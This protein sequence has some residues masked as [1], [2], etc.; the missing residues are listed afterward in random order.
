M[1]K[2]KGKYYGKMIT[3]KLEI[4]READKQEMS[5]TEMPQV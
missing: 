4:S 1:K 3:E 5:K 2:K